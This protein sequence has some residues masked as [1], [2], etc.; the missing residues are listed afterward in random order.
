MVNFW[1]IQSFNIEGKE[2]KNKKNG[3]VSID[4]GNNISIRI[5]V[6]DFN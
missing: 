4:N 5:K 2:L 3:T 6:A 1:V